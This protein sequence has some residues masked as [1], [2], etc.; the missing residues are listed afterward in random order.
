MIW[1]II[2]EDMGRSDSISLRK[3]KEWNGGKQD[4]VNYAVSEREDRVTDVTI[5]TRMTGCTLMY[6]A[7]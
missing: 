3:E 5:F 7:T 4:R 6:Q 1:D 2:K